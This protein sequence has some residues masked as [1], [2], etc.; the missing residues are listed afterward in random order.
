MLPW[1]LVPA[2]AALAVSAQT[3]A[4]RIERALRGLRPPVVVAGEPGWALRDRMVRYR[5]PAVQIALI[6]DFELAWEQA[7]G[8]A[9]DG[10]AATSDTLFQAASIGKAHTALAALRLVDEGRL[11]LDA[12][13]NG[14]LRSWKVPD[15]DLTRKQPVTLAQLLSH[16]AGLSAPAFP[17]YVPGDPLPGLVDILDG[18]PPANTT[19]V[20]VESLPGERFRYSGGGTTVVELALQDV[21]GQGFPAFMAKELFRPLGLTHATFR[22]PLPDD[23][24]REAAVGHGPSG[25]PIAGLRHV[26]PEHA[27]AGLWTTAGDL[28]RF[29]VAAAASAAGRPHAYLKRETAARMLQPVLPPAGLGFFLDA[30]GWK[31]FFGHAGSNEGF[32]C[33]L[34]VHR[35]R[36]YGAAIMTNSDNGPPLILEILRGLAE[37][38]GWEG[39]DTERVTP[40]AIPQARLTA[41]AGRYV[42]G[43]DTALTFAVK[44]GRL[45]L[46]EPLRPD[47]DVFPIDADVFVR[48]D[49][50]ARY[51]FAADA[52]GVTE[53]EDGRS[54]PG[55]RSEALVPSD[56]LARGDADGAREAY[57]QLLST[58]AQDPDLDGARLRERGL[59][60]L[61]R[62]QASPARALL[63]I[64]TA[65]RPRS[66][67]AAQ[68]LAELHLA[69]SRREAAAAAYRQAVELAVTDDEVAPFRAWTAY[70]WK[71]RLE[72]LETSPR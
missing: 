59:D 40:A 51:R 3:L 61:W 45:V 68:A 72:A 26:Y 47:A 36:G 19:A 31:G 60:L 17:G 10:R 16:T 39:A 65:L 29:G 25:R 20:R 15:N 1:L 24:L 66:A 43:S 11:A 54:R 33:L 6:Q 57:R 9:A 46:S 4:A 23:L 63:E 62:G 12:P 41:L 2:C 70:T 28:A 34:L 64:G 42:V 5:V 32:T 22:Q 52:A 38:Y 27:A 14:A 30:F 67:L 37:E 56:R 69:E 71:K 8:T 13:I 53:E 48:T 7:H 58:N 50:P 49:R 35:E 44:D 21:S 18:R 55:T